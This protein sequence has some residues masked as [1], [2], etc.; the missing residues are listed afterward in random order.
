MDMLSLWL[1]VT[2]HSQQVNAASNAVW[3]ALLCVCAD[4]SVLNILLSLSRLFTFLM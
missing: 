3:W 4:R 1:H 2:F